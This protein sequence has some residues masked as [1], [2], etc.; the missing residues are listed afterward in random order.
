[1]PDGAS[2]TIAEKP[3]AAADNVAISEVDVVV[4]S[5]W[6]SA[7]PRQVDVGPV[8]SDQFAGFVHVMLLSVIGI[9]N[10]MP[11]SPACAGV[12]LG[13]VYDVPL[14]TKAFPLWSIPDAPFTSAAIQTCWR[15]AASGVKI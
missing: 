8:P 11:R 6:Y 1:M 5:S 12:T 15:C 7:S 9:L 13:V 10:A 14:V 3:E 2:K 4:E